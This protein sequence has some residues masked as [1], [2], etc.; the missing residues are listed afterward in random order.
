M[1]VFYINQKHYIDHLEDVYKKL[2]V[3]KKLIISDDIES[4]VKEKGLDNVISVS[5]NFLLKN[6]LNKLKR[7]YNNMKIFVMCYG[8]VSRVDVGVP[9]I[10]GEHGAGQTYDTSHIAYARGIPKSLNVKYFLAVNK[11][12]Y[13][14]F[15]KNNPTLKSYIVGCPKL[16]KWKDKYKVNKENP[17][18]VFSWHWLSRSIPEAYGGFMYWSPALKE[19]KESYNIA[20]HGHPSVQDRVIPFTQAND[21]RFIKKFE[22]VVEQADIYAV[23]NSSTLFEFAAINKPVIVLNNPWFRRDVEHGMRFWEYADIGVQC[24]DVSDLSKSIDK[25]IR[26]HYTFKNKRIE[27]SQQIY[28]FMGNSVDRYI[29]VL[30]EIMEG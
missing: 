11:H 30:K 1:I 26:D 27:Y 23:D 15:K 16:D 8:N 6:K 25:A 4:Y 19:L 21:I 28:P 12:C 9:I 2:D 18:I 22:D 24:N 29:E 5:N 17:L 20:I 7:T 3:P 10:I 13:D 14:N